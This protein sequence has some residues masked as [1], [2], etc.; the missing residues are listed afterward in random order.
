MTKLMIE[1]T[2]RRHAN[3]QD[4]A[5]GFEAA[6]A[7]LANGGDWD[8]AQLAFHSA[9]TEGWAR[10]DIDNYTL[11]T[12]ELDWAASLMDD[13]IREDIHD[14]ERASDPIWFLAEYER[15]HEAKFGETFEVG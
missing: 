15:R 9:M 3:D 2:G 10:A 14:E 7:V 8:S 1:W 13:E 4:E 6:E 5:R 12:A 11:T